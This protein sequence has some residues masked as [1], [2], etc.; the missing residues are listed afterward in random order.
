MN[1]LKARLLGHKY[2]HNLSSSS[3]E[4][5]PSPSLDIDE[6][7][8][9]DTRCELETSERD[10]DERNE[11]ILTAVRMR[12]EGLEDRKSEGM[13]AEGLLALPLHLHSQL[14]SV[15]VAFSR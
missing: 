3:N 1:T 7:V 2:H 11:R 10:I 13:C 12:Y 8:E 15:Y 6:F 4:G 5:S 9:A 14:F